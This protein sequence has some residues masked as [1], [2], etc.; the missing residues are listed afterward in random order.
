MKP[1]NV[2]VVARLVRRT[3]GLVLTPDKGYLVE[4]R[5]IPLAR[6]W[7]CASPDALVEK[8]AATKDRALEDAVTDAMTTNESFFFRDKTPFDQFRD[9]V[10][11]KLLASRAAKRSITIWCAACSSGQ[12]PYS[13]AMILADMAA[14]LAGW[15]IKIVATDISAEMLAR[16][17]DGVYNQFEVQRGLPVQL[18]VKYFTQDGDKW[19]I[20]PKLRDLIDFRPF[21]LLTDPTALGRFD[22]VFCRNVLIYF[23]RE[24]KTK[25]LDG[26][27][28]VLADDGLLYLG[29][30]E[31]VIGITTRFEPMPG[32]RG[33]YT[34]AAAAQVA[35][36]S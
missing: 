9:L 34:K 4:S 7:Q 13:L 22:V 21:N 8:L 16:A 1:E 32:Q 12:E 31:T 27:A 19:K 17:R 5:L 26:V 2:D 24:T 18:L 3:S 28:R 25:V 33:I 20:D 11:P 15:R 30:A 6:T 36:A 29:G 35:A 23:D 10:L 14:K